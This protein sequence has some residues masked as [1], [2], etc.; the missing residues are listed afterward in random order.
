MVLGVLS[1]IFC[2]IVY[3][4]FFGVVASELKGESLFDFPD[5]DEKQE[6]KNIKNE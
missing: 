4:C 2:I 5:Q 3:I 6:D 1:L